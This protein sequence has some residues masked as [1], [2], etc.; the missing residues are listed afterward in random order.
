M[1][2]FF[3]SVSPFLS[4][5]VH[6]REWVLKFKIDEC[7][8]DIDAK[9]DRQPQQ[10]NKPTGTDRHNREPANEQRQRSFF[11]IRTQQAA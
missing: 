2:Y 11:P 6:C 5:R 10:C 9:V 7:V 1:Q 8:S 4:G 3:L